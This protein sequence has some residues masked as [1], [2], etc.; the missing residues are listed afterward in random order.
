[1]L[2]VIKALKKI[3][4]LKVFKR[5]KAINIS[6]QAASVGSRGPVRNSKG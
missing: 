3:K 4:M 6:T 5:I 1:M 2:K